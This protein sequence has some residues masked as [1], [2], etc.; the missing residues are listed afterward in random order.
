MPL[1]EDAADTSE[2]ETDQGSDFD[3]DTSCSQFVAVAAAAA[4]GG[5]GGG[6]GGAAAAA[7]GG[8][9]GECAIECEVSKSLPK[10]SRQGT[11]ELAATSMVLGSSE[12]SWLPRQHEGP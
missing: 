7:G 6:G 10:A 2:P 1:Q 4:A 9:R 8:G 5:G 12:V 11:L 3:E